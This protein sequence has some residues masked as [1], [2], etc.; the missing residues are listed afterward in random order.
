M[1]KPKSY[2]VPKTQDENIFTLVCEQS[3]K[4]DFDDD[5][6]VLVEFYTP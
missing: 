2:P 4:V 6:D 1:P 5:T 3:E